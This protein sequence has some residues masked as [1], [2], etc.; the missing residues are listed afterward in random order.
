MP[1]IVRV[2]ERKRKPIL[3][4]WMTSQTQSY[5]WACKGRSGPRWQRGNTW[6]WRKG[7]T[8]NQVCAGPRALLDM[9]K[10]FEQ[11]GDGD[12]TGFPEALLRIILA[13][14]ETSYAAIIA[15]SVLCHPSHVV[16][17]ALRLSDEQVAST[18]VDKV[19]GRSHDQLQRNEPHSRDCDHRGTQVI[20]LLRI[21][22]GPPY[23]AHTVS[24]GNWVLSVAP[25]HLA[26]TRNRDPE[27][28][29]CWT[30]L[31]LPTL[32]SQL[33]FVSVS[34]S[35]DTAVRRHPC[36][37]HI[38]LLLPS[39]KGSDGQHTEDACQLKSNGQHRERQYRCQEHACRP[40]W[41]KQRR[42]LRG[43]GMSAVNAKMVQGRL[44]Y[45]S[46]VRKRVGTRPPET[47]HLCVCV[48]GTN[49]WWRYMKKL[50][51]P[52]EQR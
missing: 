43:S 5:D 41:G 19:R 24:A 13:Q 15:G 52:W 25:E 44:R 30:V 27:L 3:D 7:K 36:L 51:F 9:T 21:R 17:L 20:N 46:D 45:G 18:K 22:K 40:E 48:D 37:C 47:R 50:C 6:C 32:F 14:P 1:S 49:K 12:A 39:R 23:R 33:W 38:P 42:V 10:C 2:W 35:H 31:A 26:F 8:T 16:H 11:G 4:Q 34:S 28:L 29:A